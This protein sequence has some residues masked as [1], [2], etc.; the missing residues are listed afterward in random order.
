VASG[1]LSA[2]KGEGIRRRAKKNRAEPS[3]R[4]VLGRGDQHQRLLS[5]PGL[6]VLANPIEAHVGPRQQSTVAGSNHR[7]PRA[8]R[9]CLRRATPTPP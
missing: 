7:A 6:R 1:N 5:V 8:L 3:V 2:H 4:D 9:A